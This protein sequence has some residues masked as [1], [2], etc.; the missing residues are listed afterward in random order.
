MITVELK[1]PSGMFH[2]THWGRNVNEGVPEW[3]PSP[4]R[5]I[6]ALYDTWKRKR[7]E[8]QNAQVEPLLEALAS[9]PPLFSLPPARAS[10][11]RSFLSENDRDVTRRQLV[12]DAFVALSRE[13]SIIIHWPEAELSDTQ[14][15]DLDELFSVMNYLG[16][17][18][19]WVVAKLS[20]VTNAAWNCVPVNDS[21]ELHDIEIV[22]V[23]CA[24]PRSDY[25]SKPF[26]VT[27]S[28]KGKPTVLGWLDA[29]AISASDVI[30]FK[31]SEP[32]AFQS[33]MYLRPANCFDARQYHEAAKYEPK[34]NGVL[35]GI[36]SK[37]LPP[38]TS[39][40]E[41][42]ERIRRKLMGVHKRIV[43]DPKK[44]SPKFSGKDT[45]GKPLKGHGHAYVMPLDMNRDGLLD[46]LLISCKDSF[47]LEELLA[48]DRL[49]SIWQA[50]G[51]P[52]IQ[53]VALEWGKMGEIIGTKP[54][55][56]LIS[57]TPF[58]PPRHYR[59]GR[60]EFGEWL[61]QEVA[62]AAEDHGLPKP[63]HISIIPRLISSRREIRWLEFRWLWLRTDLPRT[64]HRS[65]GSWSECTFRFGAIRISIDIFDCLD[66]AP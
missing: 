64:C 28:K 22:Q 42:S 60:G 44:V 17:S 30:D 21:D 33:V 59:K 7:P 19:S 66:Y 15:R 10:H 46:H 23:A 48:L 53:L 6:R 56:R 35:Y 26:M 20:Q 18:E 43:G 65:C 63:V 32:P 37:V 5:L 38:V 61:K 24:L 12:F 49:R 40:I 47:D 11:T 55:T 29:L 2:A 34:V 25:V 57:A 62:K 16:R 1:F 8:W 39:T 13:S 52:E 58:L 41:V 31:L 51:R 45:D 9:E 3:P 14:K 54:N 36:E 50:G 4:Y 27:A